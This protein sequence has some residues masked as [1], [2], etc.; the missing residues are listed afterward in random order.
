MSGDS[1]EWKRTDNEIIEILPNGESQIRWKAVSAEDTPK[2]MESL[3]TAYR[4]AINKELIPPLLASGG[5]VLDLL[6][7]HPFR[8]GNGRVSRLATLLLL[9][10][11]G[12]RVG[13]YISIERIIEESKESYYEFL[14]QSSHGWHEAQ[15]DPVP[16]WSYHLTTI[17]SAYREFEDRVQRTSS[18]RGAKTDAIEQAI[19][20][21]PD[22]FSVSD[23]ERLCPSV[24]RELV[25]KV[26]RGKRDAGL[27]SCTS[28][29]RGAMWYKV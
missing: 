2:A 18:Q 29:G 13:R 22:E 1:G 9:Y 23:L 15:H 3:C 27:L 7:I 26:L 11:Q 6:C 25:R 21:L 12:Y 14:F 5:F 17:R 28:R 20:S 8:D 4:H 19:E 10:Q 24:S 16:W